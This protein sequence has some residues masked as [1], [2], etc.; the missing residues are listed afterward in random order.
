MVRSLHF[1]T[2]PN[3]EKMCILDL[4]KVHNHVAKSAKKAVE[5]K[6]MKIRRVDHACI[7]VFTWL[8]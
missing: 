5:L 2:D 7:H 3:L 4:T 1:K 8:V 6:E